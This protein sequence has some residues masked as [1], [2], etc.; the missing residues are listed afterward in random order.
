MRFHPV[1][2]SRSGR[3]QKKNPRVERRSGGRGNE[4]APGAQD[5]FGSPRA[6]ALADMRAVASMAGRTLSARACV[7]VFKDFERALAGYDRAYATAM[8]RAPDEDKV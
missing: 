6:A 8:I 5:L 4:A 7:A 2:P 1:A 3:A